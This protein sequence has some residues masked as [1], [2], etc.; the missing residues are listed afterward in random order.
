MMASEIHQSS[1]HESGYEIPARLMVKKDVLQIC[2]IMGIDH[3][4]SVNNFEAMDRPR[5]AGAGRVKPYQDGEIR[6]FLRR[7]ED[8]NM[9]DDLSIKSSMSETTKDPFD[10]PFFETSL[11]FTISKEEITK[12]AAWSWYRTGLLYERVAQGLSVGGTDQE[13]LGIR[14]HTDGKREALVYSVNTLRLRAEKAKAHALELYPRL[15]QEETIERAS[16]GTTWTED[17]ESHYME[18]GSNHQLIKRMDMAVYYKD[19][20]FSYIYEALSLY[21][22]KKLEKGIQE[23]NQ[24]EMSLDSYLVEEQKRVGSLP[25]LWAEAARWS[26]EAGPELKW[27]TYHFRRWWVRAAMAMGHGEWLEKEIRRSYFDRKG[28]RFLSPGE[29]WRLLEP[30]PVKYYENDCAI[31]CRLVLQAENGEWENR[32]PAFADD[33][34]FTK[35]N[36]TTTMIRDKQCHS[37]GDPFYSFV[38]GAPDFVYTEKAK[39]GWMTE[40]LGLLFPGD[41]YERYERKGLVDVIPST[42][43]LYEQSIAVCAD[44]IIIQLEHVYEIAG[45]FAKLSPTASSDLAALVLALHKVVRR[46]GTMTEE[47]AN[48][49]Q[50]CGVV[51]DIISNYM[52]SLNIM[53]PMTRDQQMALLHLHQVLGGYVAPWLILSFSVRNSRGPIIFS[54]F[55]GNFDGEICRNPQAAQILSISESIPRAMLMGHHACHFQIMSGLVNNMQAGIKP[56]KEIEIKY[57]NFFREALESGDPEKLPV[58]TS[59]LLQ[60]RRRELHLAS[61]CKQ[62]NNMCDPSCPCPLGPL[63]RRW[64]NPACRMLDRAVVAGFKRY[65][66]RVDREKSSKDQAESQVLSEDQPERGVPE[67]IAVPN[68]ANARRPMEIRQI[69]MIPVHAD[70]IAVR[71]DYT[72][73]YIPFRASQLMARAIT[74]RQFQ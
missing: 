23:M 48:Q 32:F 11:E 53:V 31:H 19:M 60:T 5:G 13:D 54:G 50:F 62:Y 73:D 39:T 41:T 63:V 27:F 2:S 14:A 68:E 10:W 55:P 70:R 18:M 4:V 21:L 71:I 25:P 20:A 6:S 22:E 37:Y 26:L 9:A 44:D 61:F 51:M 52:E 1:E 67:A 16:W 7:P 24:P 40:T 59:G 58:V 30:G 46:R 29:D 45:A 69:L 42:S 64:N 34:Y 33:E 15:L 17:D 28:A 66:A 47:E 3:K 36:A 72:G 38:Y 57:A 49:H 8:Q 12:R 56:F 35:Y 74:D 65:F 43:S